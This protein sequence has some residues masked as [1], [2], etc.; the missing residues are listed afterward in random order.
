MGTCRCPEGF[1]LPQLSAAEPGP[2]RFRAEEGCGSRSVEQK[3]GCAC[4]RVLPGPWVLLQL[5]E[6]HLPCP[7]LS[8]GFFLLRPGAPSRVDVKLLQGKLQLR[9]DARGDAVFRYMLFCV[10]HVTCIIVVNLV[11]HQ[12]GEIKIA[13]K[14]ALS[15]RFGIADPMC[16]CPCATRTFPVIPVTSL[17]QRDSMGWQTKSC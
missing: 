2:A 4:P 1:Y 10:L 15:L 12:H 11:T 9:R 14:P 6:G 13:C 7:Q 3:H 8:F 16:L 17:L 5:P